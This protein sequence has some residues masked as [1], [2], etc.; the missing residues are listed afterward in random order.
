M[1]NIASLVEDAAAA[2][3]ATATTTAVAAAHRT[4]RQAP[5]RDGIPNNN[6]I[7][8]L[9]GGQGVAAV[10]VLACWRRMRAQ[11]CV[12]NVFAA[13]VCG[14]GGEKDPPSAG[15]S[16]TELLPHQPESPCIYHYI[17]LY[18]VYIRC[19]ACII[20]WRRRGE[21]WGNGE[22]IVTG[23]RISTYTPAVLVCVA[24]YTN[25]HAVAMTGKAALAVVLLMCLSQAID[26]CKY[27]N[28][29]HI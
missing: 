16:A 11:D 24:H 19:V 9:Y 13:T 8:I 14:G 7:L 18:G 6:I 5:P 21:D 3:T 17:I 27:T 1:Y 15:K 10:K 29:H 28:M 22:R 4:S 20:S 2:A 23:P 12:R 25:P 26:N